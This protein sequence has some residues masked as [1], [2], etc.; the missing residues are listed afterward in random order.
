MDEARGP[1]DLSKLDVRTRRR[2]GAGRRVPGWSTW[3]GR[4]TAVVAIGVLM[5]G[6]V[7]TV[8]V[9]LTRPSQTPAPS[10]KATPPAPAEEW[11]SDDVVVV[12]PS[13]WPSDDGLFPSD[14][15]WASPDE[16]TTG[17]TPRRTAAPTARVTAEPSIPWVDSPGHHTVSISGKV[18]NQAGAPLPK[19][20]VGVFE[21][22]G[23]G[24]G[25]DTDSAGNY[26]A[27]V[28]ADL[29]TLGF[30]DSAGRYASGWLG[31]AGFT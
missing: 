20:S 23:S 8:G 3:Q 2:R 30:N 9:V 29:Y 7:F 12:E 19:I 31:A 22:K 25:F 24:W 14:D 18:T 21:P 15:P 13:E 17:P 27:W 10:Q 5:A 28:P 11:P 4:L 16:P 1:D 26:E 6:S